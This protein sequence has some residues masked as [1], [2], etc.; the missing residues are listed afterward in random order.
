NNALLSRCRV[1]TFSQLTQDDLKL[2]LK[3]A[4]VHFKTLDKKVKLDTKA[5]TWLVAYANGDARQLLNLLDQTFTTFHDLSLE[6]L[7]ASAQ[8][9]LR[10]DRAGDEHYDT[11]S[12]FIKSMRAGEVNAAL[13]YCARMIKNGEQPEFI[14]RRM[15]IFA[16]EDIGL[17][18]PTALVVANEVYDAITKIGLPEAQINLAHGVAYLAGCKKDRRAH[19][20]YFEAL[21]DVE[22]YGNLEVPLYLRN[23]E[24]KL[25][26][27]LGYGVGYQKYNETGKSYLPEKL[28]NKKYLREK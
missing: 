19:D 8:T 14:A 12:A 11:I 1:Y 9:T 4:L 10:Y 22:Q 5:K 16:S 25:M 15:I 23:P 18:V 28:K 24:T 26:K 21:R 6:N 13:Y 7:K 3:K 17:A 2:V 27:E 20:A